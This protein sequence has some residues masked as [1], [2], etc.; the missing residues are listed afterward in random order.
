MMPTLRRAERRRLNGTSTVASGF[1]ALALAIAPGEASAG[2][3]YLTDDPDPAA[4][5]HWELYLASQWDHI[6]PRSAEGS[7]PHLEVNFG[8]VHGAML[9]LL[10][11]TAFVA[12]EDGR[13][14]Y[15]L[16]DVEL[17]AN[18]KL[19]EEGPGRPQI[20]TFPIA[21]IPTGS[22][23]KGLGSGTVE[24]F[25]PI[26]LMKH[27]GQWTLDAGGGIR[28]SDG[29]T[30]ADLGVFVQRS[31]GEVVSLGTELFVTL[32][33]DQSGVRTQLDLALILDL[34][35]SHHLLF[36]GG[37]SFGAV[38]GGQAYAAWMM[39]L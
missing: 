39:T 15:G 2:P 14:S 25:V 10:V 12:S 29:D 26:W 3:P 38:D 6:G 5:H 4:Y 13:T 20:G 7:L 22:D 35:D 32:P 9:H 31:F 34:S 8:V 28:F 1:L 19:L 30:E 33:F 37:P 17:G 36:S 27:M 23:A 16:G 24:L 21:V 11:P 18:I